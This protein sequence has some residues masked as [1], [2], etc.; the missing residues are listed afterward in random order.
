M[1]AASDSLATVAMWLGRIAAA[2]LFLF[3]GAFFVE[4]LAEWFL[5]GDGR[6]PPVWVWFQQ[7][8]HLGILA[9]LAAMVKWTRLGTAILV[10]STSAFIAGIGLNRFSAIALLN[11]APVALFAAA[12]LLERRAN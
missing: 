7:V 2:L 10:I 12:S 5:R 9:G 4:H 8:F 11:A 3:W 1:R 6:Y